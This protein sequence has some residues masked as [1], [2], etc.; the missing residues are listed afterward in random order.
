MTISPLE[1]SECTLQ[2][3]SNGHLLKLQVGVGGCLHSARA[4]HA[5]VK[6]QG[7]FEIC[8]IDEGS[9]CKKLAAQ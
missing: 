4:K 8:H 7:I 9:R 3:S 6:R 5:N 2:V 1:K